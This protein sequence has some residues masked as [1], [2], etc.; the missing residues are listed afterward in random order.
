MYCPTCGKPLREDAKFCAHCGSEVKFQ[1]ANQAAVPTQQPTQHGVPK[2]PI[3]A[4]AAIV[5]IAIAAIAFA[6]GTQATPA[7]QSG[8]NE[9]A[10]AP[11]SKSTSASSATATST[12]ATASADSATASPSAS[13]PAT[14]SSESASATSSSS[15]AQ[16]SAP[17]VDL[18]NP[19]DYY[20]VNIFLSNFAEWPSFY[21]NGRT[22]DRANYD[23]KQLVNW[24]MWHNAI[25]N[26]GTLVY[27]S[28]D[29]PGAPASEASKGIGGIPATR[30]LRH[31]D[32][33]LIAN[34][35][36]RY[37]GIDANLSGFNPGDGSYYERD[38]VMYEGTY[39]GDA[40]PL[41]HVALT[42]GIE[43]VDD[44]TIR[45]RFTIYSGPYSTQIVSDKSWYGLDGP[46]LES[47]M[48]AAG[49]SSVGR[50]TGTATIEVIGS[51]DNRSLKLVS[52]AVD[53]A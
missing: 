31:M 24:G 51:G 18:S 10:S 2:G 40:P 29:L 52:F 1:M 43:T 7:G 12:A 27:E 21:E 33:S 37:M 5:V 38:G 28:V 20:D 17:L 36:S 45:A 14:S 19:D 35:I 15:V 30:Y 11:S 32:T 50:K 46:S 13:A 41:G 53:G 22:Y 8:G 48:L 47:A 34:S 9:T 25:N 42:D 26:E 49:T 3:I 4:I 16:A 39:R 23:L 44:N 6:M